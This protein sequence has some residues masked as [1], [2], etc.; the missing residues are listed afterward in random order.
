MCVYTHTHSHC[1]INL[2]VDSLTNTVKVI[3]N[4]TEAKTLKV[5]DLFQPTYF[6]H[7]D[8]A[9]ALITRCTAW[10]VAEV[11]SLL[12]GTFPVSHII[13]KISQQYEET[14]YGS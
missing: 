9:D 10:T 2:T 11:S 14:A 1:I 8:W 12:N 5:R 7:R 6:A 13:N 4:F 3:Y